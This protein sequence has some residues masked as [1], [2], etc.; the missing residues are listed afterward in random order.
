MAQVMVNFR[1]DEVV[2]EKVLVGGQRL[3]LRIFDLLLIVQNLPVH[4]HRGIFG[5]DPG[6]ETHNVLAALIRVD[7]QADGL[8]VVS[9]DAVINPVLPILVILKIL[10]A[11]LA[12]DLDQL[13]PEILLQ[14]K[15]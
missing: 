3:R 2:Y 7:G 12:V 13:S 4:F 8:G 14:Q 11:C 9:R 10:K 1:M 15:V 6:L 5:G